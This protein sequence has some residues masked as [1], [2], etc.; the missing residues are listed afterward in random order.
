MKD[1]FQHEV[2]KLAFKVILF[3]IEIKKMITYLI[4]HLKKTS[5]I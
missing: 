4:F 1:S 3:F 2:D 5:W